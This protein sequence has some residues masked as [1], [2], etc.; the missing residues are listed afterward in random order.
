LHRELQIFP[1]GAFSKAMAVP[2]RPDT[3]LILP[4]TIM[5][6]FFWASWA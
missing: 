1:A 5:V 3:S 4:G 2:I 6:L